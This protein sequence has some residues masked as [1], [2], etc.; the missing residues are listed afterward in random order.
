MTVAKVKL[1]LDYEHSLCVTDLSTKCNM[2]EYSSTRCVVNPSAR[3]HFIHCCSA[4]HSQYAV[5]L[6]V[7]WFCS[8]KNCCKALS[9]A[10]LLNSLC[11]TLT[12]EKGAIW[13]KEAI[14][15]SFC[16][17]PVWANTQASSA[18]ANKILKKCHGVTLGFGW[19]EASGKL[20]SIQI[21]ENH[22]HWLCFVMQTSFGA[23]ARSQKYLFKP[24]RH[25]IL[26]MTS[27][28]ATEIS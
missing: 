16:L 17:W 21:C 1:L 7:L 28:N 9:F 23:S 27:V 15:F 24:Y 18:Y 3:H 25:V 14:M 4:F 6:E 5:A 26:F 12:S 8:L 20:W 13:K 11:I 19:F 10:N 2:A 22:I